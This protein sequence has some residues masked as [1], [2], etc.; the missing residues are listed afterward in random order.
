M[1]PLPPWSSTI[2]HDG[3]P[4]YVQRN[5]QPDG[6]VTVRLRAAPEAPVTHLFLRT[7]PDGEESL[8]PMERSGA[9]TAAVWWQVTLDPTMPLTHYRFRLMTPVDSFWYTQ[10]GLM[11]HTPTD[12]T[13]FRLLVESQ[14]AAWVREAIFYQIFPDRFADGEPANNVRDGEYRVDGRPVVARGWDERPRPETGGI[15]FFGGDLPGIVQRLS[16][17]ESLGVTAL[18]LNPIFTAPSNHKYDVASYDEVDPHLGGNAALVALREALDQRDMRLILDVV[19]NHCGVTHPWFRAAIASAAAPTADFFTIYE[20]PGNYASWLGVASLPKLN[21]QSAALREAMYAGDDAVL[22]RWLRPPYRIDGWRVDVANMLGRQGN[23]HFGH[24]VKR[25]MRRAIKEENPEAYFLGEQFFDGTD[26]LQGNELDATMNYRGF[27]RP[28]LEWLAGEPAVPGPARLPDDPPLLP[29]A[30][31]AAQWRAFL[32]EIPYEIAL[33]Q[34]NLL[35]SHDTPRVLTVLDGEHDRLGIAVALLFAFP[36]VPM[37]YYGDEVGLEGGGDPD[38]RRPMP[39]EPSTWVP[40]V[41]ALYRQWI[42]LR[43]H[44][45]ALRHGGFQLLHAADHT[46][47]FLRECREERLLLVARRRPD[48]TISLDLTAAALAD[49]ERLTELTTHL[50]R[51]VRGGALALEGLPSTGVQLWRVEG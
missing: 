24:K 11:R 23:D 31:L 32:A 25:G 27:T 47:A 4:R 40:Q 1:P 15:E 16:Y 29:T 45:P 22:R 50:R 26:F 34:F 21:Y 19:P 30:A 14:G 18:Y 43:R 48:Q 35:G 51:T 20:R 3:G 5:G 2:H 6:R 10:A 41:Q 39:W 13:D 46:V 28:V 44:H 9:T 37:I 7:T 49:G 17:L 33:Q 8:L 38:C 36:G 12:R 42:G